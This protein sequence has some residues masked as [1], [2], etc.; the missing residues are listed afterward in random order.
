ME[1]IF[2]FME[3][4]QNCKYVGNKCQREKKVGQNK[5]TKLIRCWMP[6]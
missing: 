3:G 5:I 4:A 2:V 6:G 1:R